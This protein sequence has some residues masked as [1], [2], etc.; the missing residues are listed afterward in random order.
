MQPRLS[1]LQVILTLICLLTF[2]FISL[3]SAHEIRPAVVD[4]NLDETGAYK[5]SIKINLEA[6]IS[7]IGNAHQDT[8]ESNNAGLYD[9]LRDM[10]AESLA[11]EFLMFEDKL[12]ENITLKINNQVQKLEIKSIDIPDVGDIELARDSIVYIQSRLPENAKAM[13]W[14]WD[15]S[16]GNVILRV[17]SKDKPELY[18]AYLLDGKISENIPLSIKQI[19]TINS[20]WNSFT[21]YVQVGFVH[22]VPKGLD[23]ILFVIG[24]FLL[25]ASLRPLLIQ[26]TTFT[27]AHS[28]TLALGIYGIISVPSS[29]VEPLIAASII[30]IGLEN[31]YSDKLSKWRPLVIFLFGLLHGLGFASVLKE[32]GLSSGNYITSLIGFNVGVEVGQ[33]SVIAACFLLVGVWFRHKKWYRQRVTIPASIL[34]SIIAVY[35]LIERTLLA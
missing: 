14:Q 8:D 12:L 22:I 31:I 16:L 21:N 15:K 28:V 4:I 20:T 34:I 3:V 13:T 24:L 1:L 27:I 35:W 30:Y 18:S 5:I 19:K 25:S 11:Q 9:V 6:K 23:H 2:S 10:P 26:V 7:N 17:S 29:I 32:I 33:L